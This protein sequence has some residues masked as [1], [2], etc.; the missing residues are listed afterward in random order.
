MDTEHYVNIRWLP[1]VY[2]ECAQQKL[3]NLRFCASIPF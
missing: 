1:T 3:G 2:L